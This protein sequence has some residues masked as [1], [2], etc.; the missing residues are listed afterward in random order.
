VLGKVTFWNNSDFF[1]VD[2]RGAVPK[3]K[4]EYFSQPIVGNFN[5]AT[6]ISSQRAVH[7]IDFNTVG[8]EELQVL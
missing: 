5:I 4:E 2:L 3:A 7:N 6:L 1:G 8:I